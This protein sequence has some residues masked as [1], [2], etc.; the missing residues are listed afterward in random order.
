M[1]TQG[2]GTLA[3]SGLQGSAT[4]FKVTDRGHG[5]TN[6]RHRLQHHSV[7]VPDERRVMVGDEVM[8]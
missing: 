7:L 2:E 5:R 4:T 3:A 8:K 6:G 1:T